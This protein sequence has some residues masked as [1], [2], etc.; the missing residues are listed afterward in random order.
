MSEVEIVRCVQVVVSAVKDH[1][2]RIQVVV[3]IQS[4]RER[5]SAFAVESE[6]QHLDCHSARVL[7]TREH[8]LQL[9]R[10]I[11]A[12]AQSETP[13][14]AA[15]KHCDPFLARKFLPDSR[16]AIAPDIHAV[17]SMKIKVCAPED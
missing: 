14:G 15:A 16:S 1:H 5:V 6:V 4:L 13:R 11:L 12:L 7:I 17:F 8:L 9:R 3:I 2:V 10:N